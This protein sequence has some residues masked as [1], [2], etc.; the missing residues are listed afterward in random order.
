MKFQITFKDPNGPH[1]DVSELINDSLAALREKAP[2]D[3]A[4]EDDGLEESYR[5]AKREELWGFLDK[6]I[7]WQEYI[8]IEFDT[9]T[10]TAVVIPEA[11]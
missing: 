11:G 10:G 7:R 3:T 2:D 4:L 8:T 5:E 1:H 9:E 6:W